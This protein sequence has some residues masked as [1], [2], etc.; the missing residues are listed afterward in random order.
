MTPGDAKIQSDW[1]RENPPRFISLLNQAQAPLLLETVSGFP[2]MSFVRSGQTL[3]K[4]GHQ[5]GNRYICSPPLQT[6]PGAAHSF[7]VKK[8]IPKAAK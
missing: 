5:P 8:R 1:T 4:A 6:T 2:E 3:S 7:S